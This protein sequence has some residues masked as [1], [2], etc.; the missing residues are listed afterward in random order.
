MCRRHDL[1]NALFLCFGFGS[2]FAR[3]PVIKGKYK[4]PR[5]V[6]KKCQAYPHPLFAIDEFQPVAPARAAD[7]A[8]DD[9]NICPAPTPRGG[10]AQARGKSDGGQATG[11]ANAM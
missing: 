6:S 9:E 2:G 4:R 1:E 7:L 8:R 11:A 10:V 3:Q 5:A